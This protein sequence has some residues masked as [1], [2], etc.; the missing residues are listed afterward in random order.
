MITIR[1]IFLLCVFSGC[2]KFTFR[3]KWC[4]IRAHFAFLSH[5]NGTT[6]ARFDKAAVSKRDCP[7]VR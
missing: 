1:K 3:Y 5:D 4:N 6:V 7:F 2:L